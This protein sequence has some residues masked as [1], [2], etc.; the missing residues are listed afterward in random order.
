[1]N[2][3][4]RAAAAMAAVIGLFLLTLAA[5]DRSARVL[6]AILQTKGLR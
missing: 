3:H 4:I 6:F 1:M 2:K 5:V